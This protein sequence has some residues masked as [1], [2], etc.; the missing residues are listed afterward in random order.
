MGFRTDFHALRELSMERLLYSTSKFEASDSR[1][2]VYACLGLRTAK[3]TWEGNDLRPRYDISTQECF[4][5]VAKYA[6]AKERSFALCG[7]NTTISRKTLPDLPSWVPDLGLTN[8][9]CQFALS[10]PDPPPP[11]KAAGNSEILA[12][13]PY[14]SHPNLLVTSSAK[15]GTIMHLSKRKFSNT[16]HESQGPKL[17]EWASLC[18]KYCGQAYRIGEF[19]PDAF[20]RTLVADS[21]TTWRSSPA[22]DS[23]HIPLARFISNMVIQYLNEKYSKAILSEMMATGSGEVG[24]MLNPVIARLGRDS[25]ER[26]KASPETET[27]YA[28]EDAETEVGVG[29]LIRDEA[30]GALSTTCHD[31]K[32]FVTDG[33]HIGIGPSDAEIGDEV[34]ILAGGNVP[35]VLR[36]VKKRGEQ[37]VEELTAGETHET[38]LPEDLEEDMQVYRMLGETYV[39]GVMKG[40]ALKLEGF[41]WSGIGIL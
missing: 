40:E 4:T 18:A 2:K 19:S 38:T 31:R 41:E 1:D 25:I 27:L 32:F 10:R 7:I 34:H 3:N 28:A 37:E 17:G 24:E 22:P 30:C 6:L 12:V 36:K 23:Y 5:E 21:T 39:H 13:F 35:F 15:I 14:D 26:D 9:T 33:H 20:W 8:H 16:D 29:A 11:Y